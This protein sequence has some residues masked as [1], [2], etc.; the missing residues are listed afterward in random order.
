MAKRRIERP[1]ECPRP[2]QIDPEEVFIFETSN[3]LFIEASCGCFAEFP[4]PFNEYGYYDVTR[5]PMHFELLS[6][7]EALLFFD[8]LE[9][10]GYEKWLKGPPYC[11]EDEDET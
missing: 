2:P 3:Y 10:I 11:K 1:T 8:E 5:R 4:K 6:R 7:R 9:D